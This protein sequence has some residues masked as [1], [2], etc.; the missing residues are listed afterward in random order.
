M[1]WVWEYPVSDTDPMLDDD[2]EDDEYNKEFKRLR[3]VRNG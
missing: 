2:D 1:D 3:R